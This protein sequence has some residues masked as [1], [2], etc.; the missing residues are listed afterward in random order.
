MKIAYSL[1]QYSDTISMVFNMSFS[2]LTY[3][4]FHLT[5]ECGGGMTAEI[6]KRVQFN[7]YDFSWRVLKSVCPEQYQK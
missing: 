5:W 2:K 3:H 7:T 1:P 6:F 4:E